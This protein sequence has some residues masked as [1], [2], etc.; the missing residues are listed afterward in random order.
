MSSKGYMIAF[1]FNLV[2]NT[3]FTFLCLNWPVYFPTYPTAGTVLLHLCSHL[4]CGYGG[5]G[6]LLVFY[7]FR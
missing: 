5:G 4:L 6:L 2:S 3:S 7:F 1:G